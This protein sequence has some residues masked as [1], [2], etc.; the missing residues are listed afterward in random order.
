MSVHAT[1]L[2]I[3]HHRYILGSNVKS[4]TIYNSTLQHITHFVSAVFV[5]SAKTKVVIPSYAAAEIVIEMCSY[6]RVFYVYFSG[7]LFTWKLMKIK[8][9]K[10]N[11]VELKR[12][13][14][15][16]FVNITLFVQIAFRPPPPH[17]L[18]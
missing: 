1:I 8:S 5:E 18:Y 17:Y 13:C 6:V 4:G 16:E 15:Q 10:S 3:I 11:T 9:C 12:H 7:S 2:Y 14:K